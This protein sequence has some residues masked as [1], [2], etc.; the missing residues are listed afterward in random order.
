MSKKEQHNSGMTR[1]ET[2]DV[3]T[4]EG[5]SPIYHWTRGV[6]FEQHAQAQLLNVAKLRSSTSTS[7]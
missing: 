7:Q 3:I 2:H 6:L 5:S 4:S 1:S